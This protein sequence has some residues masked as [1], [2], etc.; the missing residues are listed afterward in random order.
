MIY[1]IQ[2][3]PSFIPLP[4]VRSW[5]N[6]NNMIHREDGPAIEDSD[7]SKYFYMNDVYVGYISMSEINHLEY[8]KKSNI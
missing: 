4:I 1:K 5:F 3:R 8:T 6:Q 7:G 2:I